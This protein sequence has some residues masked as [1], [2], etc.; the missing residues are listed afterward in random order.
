[1]E[2]ILNEK[3]MALSDNHD[4]A[5]RSRTISLWSSFDTATLRCSVLRRRFLRIRPATSVVDL[6][7]GLGVVRDTP[8]LKAYPSHIQ[9]QHGVLGPRIGAEAK[10]VLHMV[11]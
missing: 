5:H 1:M 8:K 2:R 9:R 10:L 3:P 7:Q 6:D 11:V 4:L